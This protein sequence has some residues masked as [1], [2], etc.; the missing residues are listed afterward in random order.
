MGKVAKHKW[1]FIDFYSWPLSLQLA[2][3]PWTTSSFLKTTSSSPLT[4]LLE[5]KQQL[6]VKQPRK[7]RGLKLRQTRRNVQ[8]CR[9]MCKRR[10]LR[11]KLRHKSKIWWKSSR[12]SQGMLTVLTS[13]Y[14]TL[15]MW[16]LKPM[17]IFPSSLRPMPRQKWGGG[18]QPGNTASVYSVP[19]P[20]PLYGVNIVRRA[21][22]KTSTIT[23]DQHAKIVP[24]GGTKRRRGRVLAIRRAHAMPE[25][26][27]LPPVPAPPT[28]IADRA[29]QGGTVLV[30]IGAIAP[31]AKEES[32]RV[33]Q[34]QHLA[35]QKPH[36]AMVGLLQTIGLTR[37]Q[38][39]TAT[40]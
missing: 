33:V 35:L 37:H 11:S 34:A 7:W 3:Q 38:T 12:H 8:I 24:R 1:H 23:S 26:S 6:E 9:R 27:L 36:A 4:V 30:R 5:I 29:R 2:T 22:T 15:T 28:G 39:L 16:S 20:R 19:V 21:S 13:I 32:T 25:H 31:T 40:V 10:W 17:I 18:V 14:T